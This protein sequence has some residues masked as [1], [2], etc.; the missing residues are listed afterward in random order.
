[1]SKKETSDPAAEEQ[2]LSRFYKDPTLLDGGAIV[3]DVFS[4]EGNRQHFEALVSM[5]LKGE[6]PCA[7]M[8][9]FTAPDLYVQASKLELRL[10]GGASAAA[11]VEHLEKTRIRRKLAL[12]HAQGHERVMESDNPAAE[13]EV[14][15]AELNN[16]HKETSRLEVEDSHAPILRIMTDWEWRVENPGKVRGLKFGRPKCEAYIDGLKPGL[17]YV[18]GA[19]TSVGKTADVCN[20]LCFFGN[21]NTPVHTTTMEMSKDEL[22]QRLVSIEAGVSMINGTAGNGSFSEYDM[23]KIQKALM[24]CAGW[25]HLHWLSAYRINIDEWAMSVRNAK[26]KYGIQAA[27][28]DYL[29]CLAPSKNSSKDSRAEQVSYAAYMCKEIA[30][31]CQIPVI[32]L[33][34]LKRKDERWNGKEGKTVRV[35]PSISDLKESGDIENAADVIELLD[36]DR[37]NEPAVLWRQIVKQRNGKAYHSFRHHYSETYYG[38]TEQ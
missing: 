7:D 29:Q 33:S 8:M 27:Y 25:T 15:R 28:L 4:V 9:A 24:K 1:M 12:L 31:E 30:K 18:R 13:V 11:L 17:L 3:P 36:R 34:Q 14:L 20:D 35:R 2:L 21:N 19:G 22:I 23:N 26:S 10:L 37:E 6:K 16:I 5:R 32:L 38:I